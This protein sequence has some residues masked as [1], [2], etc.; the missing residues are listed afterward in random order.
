[1]MRRDAPRH[2]WLPSSFLC[3]ALALSALV[4]PIAGGVPPAM[5]VPPDHARKMA[6]GL[7]LFKTHVRP[8]LTQHCVN[9]HGGEKTKGALDLTTREALLEGGAEG[10]AIIPGNAKG[11]RLYKLI[12]HL[13]SPHMPYKAAKL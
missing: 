12:K 11:S 1:M 10:P 9:C 3:T 8:L 13:E 4:V 7:E 2:P 6:Q 5:M